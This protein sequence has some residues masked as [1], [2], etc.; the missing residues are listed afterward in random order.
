MARAK[1]C[2][3]AVSVVNLPACNLLMYR[4]FSRISP[5]VV[6]GPSNSFSYCLGSVRRFKHCQS[7]S[8]AFHEKDKMFHVKLVN[9]S[10]TIVDYQIEQSELNESRKLRKNAGFRKS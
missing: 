5:V 7:R 8:E 2:H 3:F 6:L 10:V 9:S 1:P 4:S